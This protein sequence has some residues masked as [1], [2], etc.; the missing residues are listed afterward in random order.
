MEKIPTTRKGF[1][2]LEA[3]LKQLKVVERPAIIEAIAEAREL[4]DLKENAEYHSA[5]EK[6]GFIEAR[7]ADLEDKLS[8]A[9]VIS[10]DATESDLVRFGAF[11]TV[12]D[13]DT[14]DE[15]TYRI[16]GDLEA[17]ISK[18]LISLSSFIAI[19]E[20]LRPVPLWVLGLQILSLP[21]R[22]RLWMAVAQVR[23]EWGLP[24]AKGQPT[25]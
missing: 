18:N 14:G 10:Y 25:R 7:I 3:E 5:R 9:K 16:V 24:I 11:V 17:D 15:K 4:G 6:Q 1:N 13:E 19:A 20:P 23:C 12:S 8:R 22:S 21:K 2:A